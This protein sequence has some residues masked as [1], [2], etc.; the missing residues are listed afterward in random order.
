[1]SR[2]MS[3]PFKLTDSGEVSYTT[4]SKVAMK[5]YI[6]C[7]LLTSLKER[8]FRPTYGS[9]VGTNVFET[10]DSIRPLINEQITSALETWLPEVLVENV[11]VFDAIED[12]EAVIELTYT[13]PDGTASSLTITRGALLERTLV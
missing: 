13:L 2:Y 1:M 5:Q 10:V 9:N 3:I 4:S 8:L 11:S 6:A 7:V 12:N